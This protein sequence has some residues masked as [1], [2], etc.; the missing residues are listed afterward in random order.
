VYQYGLS[1]RQKHNEFR[2][3]DAVI[4]TIVA[5]YY[6]YYYYYLVLL[7]FVLTVEVQ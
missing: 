6:Y 1:C 2:V 3:L 4:I 5:Y 7:A